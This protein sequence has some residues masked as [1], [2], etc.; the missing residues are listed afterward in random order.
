MSTEVQSKKRELERQGR[1]VKIVII[2]GKEKLKS[3][4]V[5]NEAIKSES[6]SREDHP[7]N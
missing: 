1:K 6:A 7:S 5:S 4:K 3:W 2:N